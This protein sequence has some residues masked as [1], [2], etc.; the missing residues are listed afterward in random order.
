MRGDAAL[1]PEFREKQVEQAEQVSDAG[2]VCHQRVHIGGAVL[3]LLPGVDVKPSPQPEYHGSGENPHRPAGVGH[4]HKEH[5]DDGNGQSQGNGAKGAEAQVAVAPG[6]GVFGDLR[7][8]FSGV[9]HK[10]VSRILNGSPQGSGRA[11]RS[12]V[13]HRSGRRGIIHACRAYARLAV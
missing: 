4:I 10:V 13:F 3:Q 1:Q 9:G 8:V 5:P 11:L 2:A 6:M 7:T 12:V